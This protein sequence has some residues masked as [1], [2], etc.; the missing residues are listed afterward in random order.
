MP[1]VGDLDR[2]R[3]PGR[4]SLRVGPGPVPADDLRT[5]MSLEP[6]LPGSGLP[7]G[8]QVD[9]LPGFRVGYH[10]AVYLPLAQR[11]VINSGDLGRGGDRRV[12][13]RHDQPQHGGGMDGDAQGPGQPGRSPPGQLQPEPGQHAQQR[14]AAPPV[15]LAQPPGL[16]GEGDRRAS[17]IPAAEPAHLQHDQHRPAAS[18]AV[19]HYPRIPAVDP[20]RFLTAPRAARRLRPARRDDHHRLSGVF[21]PVHAQARQV[22]EQHGEQGLALLT[23]I[24]DDAGGGDGRPGGRHGRLIRQRGSRV[25]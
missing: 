23:D 6:C 4:G 7:V 24:P 15:P 10:G 16:L 1:A 18:R 8:Q 19:R 14:D 17:R 12:G 22:R 9:H 25:Q 11:E 13:Q 2:G 3:R 20:S 5:R 21:H